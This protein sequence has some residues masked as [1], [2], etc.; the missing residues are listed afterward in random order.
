[1]QHKSSHIK[2]VKVRVE[3]NCHHRSSCKA[4]CSQRQLCSQRGWL[5]AGGTL[6]LKG[7]CDDGKVIL[8]H[9]WSGLAQCLHSHALF[10]GLWTGPGRVVGNDVNVSSVAMQE[11]SGVVW[12]GRGNIS[13][14]R[15]NIYSCF[16]SLPDCP[17]SRSYFES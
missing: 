13:A 7:M 1:M 4:G 11:G 10:S 14:A 17:S 15:E 8:A 6:L 12:K 2:K 9:A 5:D 3:E 16:F